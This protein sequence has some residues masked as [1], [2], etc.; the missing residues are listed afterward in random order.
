MRVLSK[1]AVHIIAVNLSF[2]FLFYFLFFIMPLVRQAGVSLVKVNLF[3]Y[4]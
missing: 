3:E 4:N 2:I 1:L